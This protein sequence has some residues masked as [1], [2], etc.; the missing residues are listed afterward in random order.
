MNIA[1]ISKFMK[2]SFTFSTILF[3]FL[4]Y[5]CSEKKSTGYINDL[6]L[7][8]SEKLRL[9]GK[10]KELI[11]LNNKIITLSKEEHYEKGVA[12]AYINLSNIYGT[13][14]QYK[15]SSHYLKLA[16]EVANQLNDN[17]VYAKLYNEYGQMNYVMGLT[18]TALSYNSKAKYYGE[19]LDERG[20]L[21]GNIY[22]QRA[23]FLLLNNKDSAFIYY[24]KGYDVDPS[25]LNS[26]LIGN[27]HLRK[28][29]NLDSAS[30]YINKALLTLRKKEYGNSRQGSIYSYYAQLLFE[31]KDY[32]RA[33]LFYNKA[34]A[35]LRK[36]NRTNKL[37]SLYEKISLTYK[38]LDNKEKEKEYLL[39]SNQLNDS[40]DTAS[41]ETVD[42]SFNETIE[43]KPDNKLKLNIILLFTA[44]ILSAIYLL[45]FLLRKRKDNTKESTSP[46]LD[47]AK[48]ETVFNEYFSELIDLAKKND[49]TFIN[50]FQKINPEFFPKLL[51]INHQL[52]Q[53]ELSLCAM[54]LL[55]LTSKEIA[56]FSFI[57]HRSVQT[58]KAR[59]RKKLNI[60][61]ETDFYIFLKSL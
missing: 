5:T 23:D 39:K 55:G 4:I 49:I 32:S 59:L 8:K 58:K 45:I 12:L 3:F 51:K 9:E 44:I 29:K 43:K 41:T 26:A 38:N 18:A 56:D 31:K 22:A 1:I 15:V 57:Q 16:N 10:K 17:F 61:S 30:F 53:S 13:L 34:A 37:P 28:T 14:G 46:P 6:V 47:G 20:W 27:Y 11:D 7:N 54:I 19:K 36:T 33:L 42:I 2:L 60:P 24:H 25:A 48:T 21:L 35:I 52:T 40:L 50:Q